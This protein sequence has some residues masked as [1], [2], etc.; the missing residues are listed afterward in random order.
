MGEN[1][2]V[3]TS[4]WGGALMTSDGRCKLVERLDGPGELYELF[5]DPAERNNRVWDGR[6]GGFMKACRHH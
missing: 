1:L 3:V 6:Y 4:E 5:Q 2:V